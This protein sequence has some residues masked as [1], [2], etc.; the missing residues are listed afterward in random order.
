MGLDAIPRAALLQSEE[1][2]DEDVFLFTKKRI[3]THLRYL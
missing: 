2:S 3:L 1:G